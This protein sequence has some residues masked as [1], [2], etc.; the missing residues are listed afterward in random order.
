MHRPPEATPPL[1]LMTWLLLPLPP[2]QAPSASA[3]ASTTMRR[4]GYATGDEQRICSVVMTDNYLFIL[5]I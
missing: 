2:P 1:Q 3:A 5:T 4:A